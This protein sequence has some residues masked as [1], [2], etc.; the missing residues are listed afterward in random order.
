MTYRGNNKSFDSRL[1]KLESI[2]VTKPVISIHQLPGQ[3]LEEAVNEYCNPSK[4]TGPK[5]L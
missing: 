5:P 4:P 2:I 1:K 3:S